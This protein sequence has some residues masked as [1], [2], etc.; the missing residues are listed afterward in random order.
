MYV[1]LCMSKKYE[2]IYIPLPYVSQSDLSRG[3][4]NQ[5]DR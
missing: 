2:D 5:M 3:S 4:N 1:V